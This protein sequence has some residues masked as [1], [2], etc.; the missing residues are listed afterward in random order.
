MTGQPLL[1]ALLLATATSLATT[2]LRQPAQGVP[3]PHHVT[4]EAASGLVLLKRLK[5]DDHQA[6]AGSSVRFFGF[7]DP[8]EP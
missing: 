8:D 5:S 2:P 7:W 1:V 6:A 4:L 3:F